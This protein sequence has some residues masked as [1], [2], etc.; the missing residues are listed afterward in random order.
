MVRANVPPISPRS[1]SPIKG[2]RAGWAPA[3]QGVRAV[4]RVPDREVQRNPEFAL[5]QAVAGMRVGRRELMLCH[6]YP[7]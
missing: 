4:P 1:S 2:T 3:P 5:N 6:V 7:P